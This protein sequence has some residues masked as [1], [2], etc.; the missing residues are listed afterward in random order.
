MLDE[1][2]AIH[3][4][5][6]KHTRSEDGDESG[7]AVPLCKLFPRTA[8]AVAGSAARGD[9][10]AVEELLSADTEHYLGPVHR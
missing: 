5:T 10:A 9:S 8:S 2:V 7:A 6:H 4:H 3:T 1:K